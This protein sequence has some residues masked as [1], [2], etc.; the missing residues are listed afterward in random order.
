MNVDQL[1]WLR[2][3]IAVTEMWAREA[4]DR[5]WLAE[6][7][8]LL[9][10]NGGEVARFEIKADARHAALNEPRA[11]LA[12]CE[13][14]TAILDYADAMARPQVAMLAE[15]LPADLAALVPSVTAAAE[16]GASHL[17]ALVAL[18][19]QHRPGYR[20]EWKP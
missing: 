4:L 10:Q 19:Y 17:R 8:Y 11:A 16:V 18:A 7:N 1:P 15:E 5:P 20:E 2:E 3:Q 6:D 12:Q 13:A 9:D 14:H